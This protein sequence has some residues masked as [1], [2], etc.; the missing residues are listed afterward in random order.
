[1]DPTQFYISVG[2]VPVTT[3]IIVMIGVVL[4]NSNMNHRL[5][6]LRSEF[7]GRFDSQGGQ[8]NSRFD[9]MLKLIEAHADRHDAN[10]RRVE[11]VLDARLSRI[12][13]H[14]HLR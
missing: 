7:V 9:S 2:V 11:D 5:N 8:F 10:L 13:D 6:D 12:E 3:I 4:N 14:L 1:M